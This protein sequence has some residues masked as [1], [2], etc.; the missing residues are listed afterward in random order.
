MPRAVILAHNRC[1]DL[2]TNL[3]PVL[4]RECRIITG[5]LQTDD[6]VGIIAEIHDDLIIRYRND[7]AG[8]LVALRDFEEGSFQFLRVVVHAL[9]GSRLFLLRCFLGSLGLFFCRCFLC[10]SLLCRSLFCGCLC[11][12]CLCLRCG[13]CL[14]GHF[15][16]GFGRCF[17][18][19]H[20]ISAYFLGSCLYSFDGSYTLNSFFQHF[21][22]QF[23]H[24]ITLS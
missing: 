5:F 2:L 19:R 6:T 13:G 14:C 11:L 21:I 18:F 10:R 22:L 23:I 7:C 15:L 24:N 1:G 4:E 8:Q 17:F 3:N 12:F 20:C 16:C 9:S